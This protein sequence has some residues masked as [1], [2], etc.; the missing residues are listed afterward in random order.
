MDIFLQNYE[1]L[2]QFND[3]INDKD[4]KYFTFTQINKNDKIN[5]IL[6]IVMTSHNRSKQ[7]Y[8]TLQTIINSKNKNIQIIIVDD[9]TDDPLD[10]NIL[11]QF[12]IWITFVSVINKNKY[13]INPCV[14]YNIGFSFIEGDNVIIQNSEVCHVGDVCEFVKKNITDTTYL[15][16]DVRAVNNLEGNEMIYNSYFDDETL[17]FALEKLKVFRKNTIDGWYQHSILSP[18]SYH[19]LSAISRDN[20]TKIGGFSLDY[21]LAGSYDDDDLLLKIKFNSIEIKSINNTIDKVA[22][23]HLFHRSSQESW[24][25]PK[26]SESLNRVIFTK[27][28][29]IVRRG[30]YIDLA[31]NIVTMKNKKDVVS[32]IKSFFSDSTDAYFD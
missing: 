24:E 6:S 27:K 9:S 12:P 11:K 25:N 32:L 19:F 2:Y 26:L 14:N 30:K 10:I 18:S 3:M 31:N 20:L 7:V 23:I 16:F 8:F 17:K 1:K 13:W 22:G 21:F 28:V 5:N 15:V 29:N 4:P